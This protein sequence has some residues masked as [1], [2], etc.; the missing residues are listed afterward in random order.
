MESRREFIKKTA[1]TG[2]GLAVAG[3]SIVNGALRHGKPGNIPV[4]AFSK[5]FQFIEDFGELS[6]F[7]VEGGTDGLDLTLRPG[8]HIEPEN[9][10]K[11]LPG[12]VAEMKKRG[13]QAPMIVTK[14]A[15]AKDP[16]TDRVLKAASKEGVGYYRMAYLSYDDDLGIEKSIEK[17]KA[18]FKALSVINKKYKIQGAY[19]NHAGTRLGGPVWD[20]Y[21]VLDGL[22]PAWIGCQY[23]I[24]HAIV[25]GGTS[26]P[27]G[28]ELIKP[29]VSC[30]DIKDFRWEKVNGK[31][32][33]L[34]VP[35]GEGMVDFKKF[36]G[37]L[38]ESDFS[39]PI[40]LHIE[41][42]MY[43]PK[44]KTLTYEHKRKVAMKYLKHDMGY[45]KEK[46]SESGL[47]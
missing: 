34:H 18:E 41:Y 8:G 7:M 44:D 37:Y 25:E 20:L 21:Q 42:Q 23:D 19:Q 33:T 40:S 39:G 29:Y 17:F 36:F 4:F 22:D 13:L 45:L 47:I 1:L 31:W 30:V 16:L 32:K 35:M 43:D 12:A 46:M 15:D 24:R 6:D 28:W 26:W 38:K 5:H 14:I 2:A 11:F 3:S 9:V 27:L 10:E